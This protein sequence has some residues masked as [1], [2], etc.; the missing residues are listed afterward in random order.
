MGAS[1]RASEI[2]SFLGTPLAGGDVEVAR[3]RPLSRAE[4]GALL[5]VKSF[6]PE[7]A[8]RLN[9]ADGAFVIA[10]ET[11]RGHL[12][13]AHVLSANPRL[14]FARVLARFFAPAP[15]GPAISPTASIA[16]TAKLGEG[17]RIGHFVVVHDGVEIG[18][19]T[20]IRDG[21]VLRAGTRIGR[22]CLVKSST[23]IGDE[24]FGFDFAPDGTPIRVPHHGGVVIGDR[25]E[26]GALNTVV[27]GTLDDTV[28]G[29]DV[30]TDDHVHIAHNC[31]IGPR[32]IIT[33]CA[34]LSGSV[35][36]GADVWIG[37]QSSVNNKVSIGDRALLGIGAVANKDVEGVMIVGGNPARVLRPR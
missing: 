12:S 24:G 18:D 29:D 14:D 34:E 27:R 35:R 22:D 6:D 3:P 17:V 19:R 33:A 2:A 8:A 15:S 9:G 7:T 13:G 28:V 16:P 10:H 30:K 37:P 25:V 31:V 36:V 21:V 5:F 1:V 20:E 4:P 26:I 32:T 23:V 11:F